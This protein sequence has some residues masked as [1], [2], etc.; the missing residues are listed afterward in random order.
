M[1]FVNLYCIS[2][3]IPKILLHLIQVLKVLATLDEVSIFI[4]FL[5][6]LVIIENSKSL[7]KS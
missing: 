3:L 5:K 6:K 4:P 2:S 7:M 1:G